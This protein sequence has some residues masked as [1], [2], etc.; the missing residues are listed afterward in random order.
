MTVPG[1]GPSSAVR[2]RSGDRRRFARFDSAHRSSP[3]SGSSWR[4]LELRK[5]ATLEHHQAGSS[6]VAGCSDRR[7]GRCKLRVR[8][9]CAA[10]CVVGGRIARRRGAAS[11]RSPSRA[12]G[13]HPLCPLARRYDVRAAPGRRASLMD[14]KGTT[15]PSRG[16][17]RD[18][19]GEPRAR[20]P[21]CDRRRIQ[22]M[23][24]E[25]ECSTAKARRCCPCSRSRKPR[26]MVPMP[27]RSQPH[28]A[29]DGRAALLSRAARTTARHSKEAP[30]GENRS[31]PPLRCD[32]RSTDRS[33]EPFSLERELIDSALAV[34][35]GERFGDLL[36]GARRARAAPALRAPGRTGP[37]A[38]LPSAEAPETT[39]TI[40]PRTSLEKRAA[41]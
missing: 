1:I 38:L 18:R 9:R 39:M 13:G 34:A 11:P 10:A 21:D 20:R 36:G 16:G 8:T 26:T 30:A 40:S 28:H 23:R 37:L 24:P 7:P 31:S 32:S 5:T 6:S 19:P 22:P 17:D 4:E 35:A 2:L 12:A 3:T 15:T 41:S 29:R 25:R 27:L 33:Q 14:R